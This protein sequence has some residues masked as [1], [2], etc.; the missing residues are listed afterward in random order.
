[1][2][3]VLKRSFRVLLAPLWVPFQLGCNLE[4]TIQKGGK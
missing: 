2:V 3:H 4:Q 1:M